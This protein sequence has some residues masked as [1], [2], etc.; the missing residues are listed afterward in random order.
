MSDR[1]Q[2]DTP[3]GSLLNQ[4]VPMLADVPIRLVD[5][6][7]H[8]SGLPRVPNNL[9]SSVRN[10]RDVYRYY[11]ERE[12]LAFLREYEL[13]YLPGERFE[14]S[15]L[16]MG[17]LGYLIGVA[18]SGSY[19]G[20][21]TSRITGPLGMK[22]TIVV[23]GG[24]QPESLLAGHN[25]MFE[26]VPSSSLNALAASGAIYTSL[27]DMVRYVQGNL[28]APEGTIGDRLELAQ[29]PHSQL[30]DEGGAVGLGWMIRQ[31]GDG[32]VFWHNSVTGGHR[33]FV[34]FVK[35]PQI[36]SVVLANAMMR[37]I[38]FLGGHLLDP[39]IELP[40]IATA[41]PVGDY[42]DYLG[43]YQFSE[44]LR[45]RLTSDGKNLYGHS[46]DKRRFTLV[47]SAKDE[48]SVE[49][50][51]LLIGFDRSKTGSIVRIILSDAENQRIGRKAGTEGERWIRVVPAE[52]LGRYVGTYH[53]SDEK[54]IVVVRDGAQ[55]F[56]Q[57]TDA[58]RV[59]VYAS[60]KTRFYFDDMSAEIEFNVSPG[61]PASSLTLHQD[62][63]YRARRVID[64]S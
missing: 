35:G 30:P 24:E 14:F 38:D 64:P 34:A 58:P 33:S 39:S 8:S 41:D 12:L 48:F 50:S 32:R 27:D 18:Q 37:E 10:S 61:K 13:V 44:G 43:T 49:G 22:S 23:T 3:I 2:L 55:L 29:Q 4:K 5:L 53:L 9:P 54:T 25:N 51:E 42:A 19:E 7:T 47:R 16:G 45:L 40:V 57:M 63:K 21:L 1:V 17:L 52:T 11:G 60:S 56:V 20:L 59:P 26:T 28:V 46:A 36:G 15:S 62:G 31:V 6:A